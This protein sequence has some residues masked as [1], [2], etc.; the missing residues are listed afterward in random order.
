M[1]E[2]MTGYGETWNSDSWAASQPVLAVKFSCTY[3]ALV[4][5]GRLMVTV[6]PVAGLNVYPAE[7]TI[8]VKVV[9]LALPST[10]R[11]S[12]RG[13]QLLNGGRS[14]AI[15]PMVCAEPRFTVMVCGYP[16]PSVLSQ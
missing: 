12:V 11:V 9:P 1:G 7:P 16:A 14:R 6:L 2:T 4:P 10:D 15:D 8:W 13:F 5:D 3:W